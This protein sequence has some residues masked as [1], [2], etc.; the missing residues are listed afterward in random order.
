M[1]KAKLT[2]VDV[3]EAHGKRGEKGAHHAGNQAQ[4]L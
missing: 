4:L 2:P 1:R 3:T